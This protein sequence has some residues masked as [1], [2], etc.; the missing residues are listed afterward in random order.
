MTDRLG[1]FSAGP[2]LCRFLAE[3]PSDP[4]T[5]IDDPIW[6]E[7]D[8][9]LPFQNIADMVE[10]LIIPQID[11]QDAPFSSWLLA[12]LWFLSDG[13]I[14]SSLNVNAHGEGFADGGIYSAFAV[15]NDAFGHAVATLD[16]EGMTIYARMVLSARS[17]Q[18]DPAEIIVALVATLQEQ[19]HDLAP[20][21][22]AIAD[23]EQPARI[24]EYGWDGQRFLGKV[25]DR[26]A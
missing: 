10:R 19:P 12:R 20:C 17:V 1:V 6:G 18:V 11:L 4:D 15:L 13:V 24:C 16:I 3:Q 26:R 7:D 5:L 22:I 21:H 9:P 14:G 25:N 2:F 8:P 23:P